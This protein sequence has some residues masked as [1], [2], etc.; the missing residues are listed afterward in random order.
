VRSLVRAGF[1]APQ[2]IKAL[3]PLLPCFFRQHRSRATR[4]NC[5]A[6]V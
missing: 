3:Q 2:I 6:A 4:T 5:W 1:I